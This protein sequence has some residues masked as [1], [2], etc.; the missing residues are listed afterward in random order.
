MIEI[1]TLPKNYIL[2]HVVV[3][4]KYVILGL[5]TN[6]NQPFDFDGI[7]AENGNFYLGFDEVDGEWKSVLRTNAHIN[8]TIEQFEYYLTNNEI[9]ANEIKSEKLQRLG[10]KFIMASIAVFVLFIAFFLLLVTAYGFGIKF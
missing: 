2:V 9:I 8:L 6:N 1:S 4:E 3:P 7:M 5:L 10:F